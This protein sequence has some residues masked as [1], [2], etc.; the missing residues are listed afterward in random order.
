MAGGGE[1]RGQSSR[2]GDKAPKR[3]VHLHAGSDTIPVGIGFGI[4]EPILVQGIV[5]GTRCFPNVFDVGTFIQDT[6]SKKAIF[7][8]T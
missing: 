6:L 3:R 1:S 4:N 2:H 8:K 7:K 5:H